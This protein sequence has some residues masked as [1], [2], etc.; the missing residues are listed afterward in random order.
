MKL[1]IRTGHESDPILRAMAREAGVGVEKI[2]EIAV[3]N[4]LALWIKERGV[5]DGGLGVVEGDVTVTAP[6]HAASLPA[7]KLGHV[8]DM[9]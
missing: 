5:D 7:R 1:T 4:L 8:R 9:E 6:S 2:A 3:Y